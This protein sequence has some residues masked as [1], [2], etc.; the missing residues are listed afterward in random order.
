MC[1]SIRLKN[2]NDVQS[3][4]QFQVTFKVD[5]KKYGFNGNEDFVDCC[6]CEIDL[7]Q[8]FKDHPKHKFYYEYGEWWEK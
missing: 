8:F 1:S 2:G 5:A 4:R 7:E 6:M 3:V